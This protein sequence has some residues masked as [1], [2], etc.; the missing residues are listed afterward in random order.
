DMREQL[1]GIA[2][3][4]TLTKDQLAAAVTELINIWVEQGR[5]SQE[6]AQAVMAQANAYVEVQAK[7]NATAQALGAA[8]A[9]AEEL[10]NGA[11]QVASAIADIEPPKGM[12]KWDEYLAKLNAARDMVGMNARELGE[13]QAAQEGANATQQALSGIITAQADEFRN[14]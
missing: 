12:D 3:D 14:L 8:N 7:A 4:T 2:A 11:K 1:T 5:I 10:K 9:R 13:Y 6:S